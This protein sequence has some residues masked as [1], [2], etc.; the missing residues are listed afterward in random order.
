MLKKVCL[1]Q[2]LGNTKN[3]CSSILTADFMV[4]LSFLN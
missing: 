3:H 2:K 1:N 4:F